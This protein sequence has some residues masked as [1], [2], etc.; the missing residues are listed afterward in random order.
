MRNLARL[1]K[2]MD[3]K[4]KI[5]LEGFKAFSR[6]YP[7]PRSTDLLEKALMGRTTE[8]MGLP[9][10]KVNAYG[11]RKANRFREFFGLS[12][13]GFADDHWIDVHDY[14]HTELGARPEIEE[15]EYRVMMLY[16]FIGISG[17]R[18]R[19]LELS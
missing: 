4:L 17:I 10:L 16:D 6:P 8:S 3:R 5:A 14:L 11:R 1:N 2:D 12:R 7:F 18:L 19:G 13:E 9:P 15:D